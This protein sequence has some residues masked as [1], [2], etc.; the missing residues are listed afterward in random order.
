MPEK[1]FWKIFAGSRKTAKEVS[2]ED[3]RFCTLLTT[4]RWETRS[5]RGGFNEKDKQHQIDMSAMED[6]LHAF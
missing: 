3:Y 4:S 1:K 2:I 6:I 5:P